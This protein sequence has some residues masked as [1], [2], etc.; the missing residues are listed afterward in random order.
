M[1]GDEYSPNFVNHFNEPLEEY[2]N[3]TIELN[4]FASRKFA[5]LVIFEEVIA[6]CA[7]SILQPKNTKKSTAEYGSLIETGIGVSFQNKS[8]DS[9][10]NVCI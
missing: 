5:L 7:L 4:E 3:H 1:A 6:S 2:V 9:V 10:L 8:L